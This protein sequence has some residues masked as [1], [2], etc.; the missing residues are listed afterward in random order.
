MSFRQT[1]N[2]G[3]FVH[4]DT[5]FL[6]GLCPFNWYHSITDI[7]YINIE[8]LFDFIDNS[9]NE[10]WAITHYTCPLSSSRNIQLHTDRMKPLRQMRHIGIIL[11]DVETVLIHISSTWQSLSLFYMARQCFRSFWLILFA[12]VLQQK[13]SACVLVNECEMWHLFFVLEMTKRRKNA[14]HTEQCHSMMKKKKQIRNMKRAMTTAI[15]WP[16]LVIRTINRWVESGFLFDRHRS[17][18]SLE[19]WCIP[20]AMVNN[21]VTVIYRSTKIRIPMKK[22]AFCYNKIQYEIVLATRTHSLARMVTTHRKKIIVGWVMGNFRWKTSQPSSIIYISPQYI[23]HPT[24]PQN[25]SRS[26][27]YIAFVVNFLDKHCQ[28]TQCIHI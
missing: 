18:T 10:R 14:I 26:S 28:S 9:V 2:A 6:V 5:I 8:L 13:R 27:S 22:I 4:E 21:C 11:C 15:R 7:S 1:S 23:P 24:E 25:G 19:K 20:I 16:N 3:H 12:H 17:F